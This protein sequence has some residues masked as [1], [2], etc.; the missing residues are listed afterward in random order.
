[1]NDITTTNY[2][3]HNYLVVYIYCMSN[4][5]STWVEINK[6]ALRH[7][8]KTLKR[9]LKPNVL[10]TTIVKANGYGHGAVEV[11]KIA[12][13]NGTDRLAVE[14]VEEGIELRK[15]KINTPILVLSA[16]PFEAISEAIDN[17]LILSI[18][19]LE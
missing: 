11:S 9:W 14:R 3:L 5:S 10:L 19:S 15:A 17:T 2:I 7:N 1:M 16:I 6:K 18:A 12:I 13:E 8:I 4:R